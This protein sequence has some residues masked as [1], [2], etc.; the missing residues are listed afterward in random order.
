MA[1]FPVTATVAGCGRRGFVDGHTARDV[2]FDSPLELCLLPDHRILLSDGRNNC[3]RV[4]DL[5]RQTVQTVSTHS[6]LGVRSPVLIDGGAAVVVSDSGHNKLRM[7]QIRPTADGSLDVEDCTIAGTGR[8]ALVDG[9]AES[10]C[11]SRPTGLCV[12]T[13]GSILVADTGNHC[14]RRIAAKPGRPGLQVTTIAGS[15]HAGFTDGRGS[16]ASFSGP[17]ALS[18]TPDGTAVVVSDAGNHALRV[19]HGPTDSSPSWTVTTLLGGQPGFEDG[20]CVHAAVREPSCLAVLP[21]TEGQG[22]SALL[23]SDAANNAVRSFTAL[24]VSEMAS[25]EVPSLVGMSPD[26]QVGYVDVQE[27][28]VVSGS[29]DKV[30]AVLPGSSAKEGLSRGQRNRTIVVS[31]ALLRAASSL[32]SD[33]ESRRASESILEA[34][35][36][37]ARAHATHTLPAP[38]VLIHPNP[39]AVLLTHMRLG[40]VETVAGASP[41]LL[42]ALSASS[43]SSPAVGQGKAASSVLAS[44]ASAAGLQHVLASSKRFEDGPSVNTARFKRPAGLC[45]L[46]TQEGARSVL[47]ADSGNHFI[48]VLLSSKALTAPTCPPILL[49][50]LTPGVLAQGLAELERAHEEDAGR[51]RGTAEGAGLHTT[52]RDV[53]PTRQA[54]PAVQA[55]AA[56]GRSPVAAKP[57]LMA[58]AVSTTSLPVTQPAPPVSVSAAAYPTNVGPTAAQKPTSQPS[59]ASLRYEGIG[60]MTTAELLAVID[61]QQG[62][63]HG[64]RDGLARIQALSPPTATASDAVRGTAPVQLSPPALVSAPASSTDVSAPGAARMPASRR[65]SVSSVGSRRSVGGRRD[66]TQEA[67]LAVSALQHVSTRRVGTQAMQSQVRRAAGSAPYMANTD[68][69]ARASLHPPSYLQS[70]RLIRQAYAT[71]VAVTSPRMGRRAQHADRSTSHGGAADV[72]LLELA[73]SRLDLQDEDHDQESKQHGGTGSL[74]EMGHNTPALEMLSNL[75]AAV[76]SRRE[77]LQPRAASARGSYTAK[78]GCAE[79][80][81]HE[82]AGGTGVFG[83]AAGVTASASGSM[84][85]KSALERSKD[86]VGA[87]LLA[88]HA[89]VQSG[90]GSSR[91]TALDVDSMTADPDVLLNV[92]AALVD[93]SM[94]RSPSKRVQMRKVEQTVVP[95]LPAVL[96]PVA[97]LAHASRVCTPTLA[98]SML[99]P[100]A[101]KTSGK[102]GLAGMQMSAEQ[103]SKHPGSTY[104]SRDAL[105]AE[106]M[107]ASGALVRA[108]LRTADTPQSLVTKRFVRHTLSSVSRVRDN[109]NAAPLT[110]P[111]F[112]N[113]PK[114]VRQQVTQLKAR[115]AEEEGRMTMG[116]GQRSVDVASLIT[117][118]VSPQ[119][120]M[121]GGEATVSRPGSAI[122]PGPMSA[123]GVTHGE[124]V[125]MDASFDVVRALHPTFRARRPSMVHSAV[126]ASASAAGTGV[127]SSALKQTG[128]ETMLKEIPAYAIMRE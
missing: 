30:V 85:N 115:A 84:A 89:L 62:E 57:A 19:L 18:V 31:P 34:A 99:Q 51:T 118:T 113:V 125:A 59:G 10:A 120:K 75:N 71:G 33:S 23:L 95:V 44:A 42:S 104:A 80:F 94:N 3:L 70:Q 112:V 6:F 14:I 78:V 121:L 111:A 114:L 58:P 37:V 16:E 56:T 92:S 67:P 81:V 17:C 41:S 53:A 54:L 12:H 43:T 11:F 25:S 46:P 1:A 52:G 128:R 103:A 126:S 27:A 39:T 2:Y 101:I 65:S 49:H 90:G 96:A 100:G 48:R 69:R 24:S 61:A 22:R 21:H 109:G 35:T 110:A 76:E 45:V 82:H 40:K 117:R 123:S 8:A 60:G 63:E 29:Q 15:G 87:G 77:R 28:A 107:D 102:P 64:D 55:N 119:R 83:P 108:L 105:A 106:E 36:Q 5:P 127:N 116:N 47:V 98:A 7:L 86:P 32:N 26:G 79:S 20:V 88:A 97:S 66:S 38:T 4:L 93:S 50:V 13:D 73:E 9:P 72:S 74:S 124:S 122:R 91:S 68:S